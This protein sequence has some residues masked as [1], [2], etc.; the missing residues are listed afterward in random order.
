MSNETVLRFARPNSI[1]VLSLRV[2]D[3]TRNRVRSESLYHVIRETREVNCS[4]I[5]SDWLTTFVMQKCK[6]STWC[7]V[8]NIRYRQHRIRNAGP[9]DDNTVS[10]PLSW[11]DYTVRRARTDVTENGTVKPVKPSGRFFGTSWKFRFG[12]ATASL[13]VTKPFCGPDHARLQNALTAAV[14]WRS[15]ALFPKISVFINWVVSNTMRSISFY[16]HIIESDRKL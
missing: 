2:L 3:P 15:L 6:I 1:D 9:L 10:W 11:F 14:S 7:Y 8:Q 5:S 13:D 12:N 16:V 4:V